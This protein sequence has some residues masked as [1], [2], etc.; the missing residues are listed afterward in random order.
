MLGEAA[1]DPNPLRW[2]SD[3]HLLLQHR[4]RIRQRADPVPAQLH[5]E[6]E[7]PANDVQV[8]VDKAWKD[9]ARFEVDD[10]GLCPGKRHDVLISSDCRELAAFDGDSACRRIGTIQR[11][12]QSPMQDK[13]WCI[14]SAL[15][16]N[17]PIYR[18]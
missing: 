4:H 10:A 16:G 2:W 13:I 14:G 7:S 12:E 17:S 11:R 3:G 8:I 9:T 18:W 15:H 1:H 5:V 6:V